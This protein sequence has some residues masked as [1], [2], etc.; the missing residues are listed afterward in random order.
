[1]HL[2]IL[3]GCF[4][5]VRGCDRGVGV[6]VV[7]ESALV[8]LEMDECKALPLHAAL[9]RQRQRQPH[10]GFGRHAQHGGTPGRR[11]CS[12]PNIAATQGLTHVHISA[13]SEPFLSLIH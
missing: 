12:G 8:G 10:A 13:R 9:T 4:G 7:S 5:S 11:R 1:M 2:G 6:Y 3:K